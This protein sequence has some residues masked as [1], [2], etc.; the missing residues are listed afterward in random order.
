MIDLRRL[1]CL[2]TKSFAE[3]LPLTFA[4]DEVAMRH[5]IQVVINGRPCLVDGDAAFQTLSPF[6]RETLGLVGTKIVCSEGD[7]GACSVLVGRVS[8]DRSKLK[9]VAIDSCIVF[10][11]QLDQTHIVTV[12]GL[13]DEEN[14][15]P[16][17][18]AMVRCHGSQCGF[19]TPGFVTTLHGL[20]E[21]E[22]PSAGNGQKHQLDDD[23]IRIGLSGNLC[24]CTG[25]VQ[26]ID[27]AKSVSIADMPRLNDLY[28]PE[29][30][31]EFFDTVPQESVSIASD[32]Q[33][34][35]IPKG[36]DEAVCLLAENRDARIVS[37]ATDLGVQHNHGQSGAQVILCLSD[38]NELST[39]A[40]TKDKVILGAGA[41]W[42]NII[43]AIRDV[44]PEF[45]DVLLR[46]GSPQIRNLG[47]IGGNLANASPIADS[48]PFLY[49][50]GAEL[51]LISSGDTR[52]LPIEDFFLGY[53]QIDLQSGELIRAIHCPRL[54]SDESLKLYKISRRRDMD[55]STF[56]AAIR[57]KTGS[58]ETISDATIA[59][60]GVGPTVIRAPRT[61]DFLVGRRLDEETM[62]QSG[63]IARS[64]ITPITDVRGSTDYRFQLAENVMQKFYHDASNDRP[65]VPS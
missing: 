6:L 8:E 41:T 25:Y 54:C 55:I 32:E 7:C 57:V 46:F 11:Y 9:Y 2:S 60:G 23:P 51:E 15:S 36:I 31:I 48:I 33:K 34:I 18:E 22:P 14:L 35:L 58:D 5:S 1:I 62:R 28:P 39:I 29:P 59:F 16:I 17:Q 52:T 10:M 40:M 50:I 27:A 47:T 20:F 61:E 21:A 12:E 53:K 13:G 26:I 45:V 43:D 56:T 63:V 24:R 64:E 30:I 49:S 42:T 19:C 3:P 38:V 37:G 4:V 44:F 65:R